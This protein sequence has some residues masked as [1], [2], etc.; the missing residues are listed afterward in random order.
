M[1]S[2]K[3]LKFFDKVAG[4]AALLGLLCILGIIIFVIGII[5]S[6]KE[7]HA[8]GTLGLSSIGGAVVFFTIFKI[9]QS[10]VDGAKIYY[11][12]LEQNK[13]DESKQERTEIIKSQYQE[14]VTEAKCPINPFSFKEKTFWIADEALYISESLDSYI[15][16]N[17]DVIESQNDINNFYR[18]S[19]IYDKIL[20][21]KIQY[22]A[23][24]GDV[25]Y[26]TKVS[27]GG[28]GGSSIKGAIIGG[29]IAG[30]AGAIIG[31]RQKVEEV[32]ST[33]E[34]HDSRQTIIRYYYGESL[35]TLTFD[36]YDVYNFLLKE[37]PQKDL[38]TIQ[39]NNAVP[40]E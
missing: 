13:K 9:A 6:D 29:I 5:V 18:K 3:R 15:N 22:Y 33:T 31:S 16:R 40:I 17:K 14:F 8:L 4:I 21:S 12:M 24:E 32:H 36:G 39:I 38:I 10:R 27:G 20:I 23:K 26:T 7:S 37:I 2:D 11:E 1:N 34:T 25:Q 30:E 28:G 35:D 19:V